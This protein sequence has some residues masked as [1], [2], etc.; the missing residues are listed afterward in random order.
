MCHVWHPG[1]IRKHLFQKVCY[2]LRS[3]Q[4]TE[5]FGDIRFLPP[6]PPLFVELRIIYAFADREKGTSM[7]NIAWAIRRTDGRGWTDGKWHGSAASAQKA[8]TRPRTEMRFSILEILVTLF[9]PTLQLN[10]YDTKHLCRNASLFIYMRSKY[11]ALKN[12]CLLE[13]FHVYPSLPHTS[14]YSSWCL[15]VAFYAYR[16][17]YSIVRGHFYPS[18]LFLVV[19]GSSQSLSKSLNETELLISLPCCTV[20]SSMKGNTGV[21]DRQPCVPLVAVL[22]SGT[23]EQMEGDDQQTEWHGMVQPTAVTGAATSGGRRYLP[24][25]CA[26]SFIEL[27]IVCLPCSSGAST[28]TPFW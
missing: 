27:M 7:W 25:L 2:E 24:L 26:F 5:I 15:F 16:S 12:F 21:G 14:R 3:G 10:L 20:L 22:C 6:P 9:L 4:D 11:R 13:E 23:S 17:S 18:F 1:P 19:K 28:G 8:G